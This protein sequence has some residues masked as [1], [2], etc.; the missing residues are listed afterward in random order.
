M[1]DVAP[2]VADSAPAPT[3]SVDIAAQVIDTAEQETSVA[4]PAGEFASY[5]PQEQGLVVENSKPEAEKAVAKSEASKAAE[6]LRKLGHDM[7]RSDGRRAFM[8]VDTVAKMLDRYLEEG[9]STWTGEKTTL[10]QKIAEFEKH[11]EE[12]YA[13][14]MGDPRAFLEKLSGYD[15]RYKSFIEQ[16]AQQ[17]TTAQA[18][19]ADEG[20]PDGDLPLPDGSRTFSLDGV[21]RT[22]VPWIVKQVEAGLMPKVDERLKPITEREQQAKAQAER[23]QAERASLD[24]V[25]KQLD[26]AQSWPNWA[27]YKDDVYKLLQEDTAKAKAEQR[28]PTLGLSEAYWR[29]RATKGRETLIK[30]MQTAPKAPALARGGGDAPRQTGPRSSVDIVRQVVAE[31]ERSA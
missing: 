4:P 6:F 3:P 31:A 5:E 25:R 17:Q 7:K 28:R 19:V 16:R 10:E 22:L 9:N 20:F 2:V 27:D 15:P 18:L 1:S 23:E 26:E 24:R 21:K 30:E 11:R 13:D 12:M 8:P 14:I 29:I